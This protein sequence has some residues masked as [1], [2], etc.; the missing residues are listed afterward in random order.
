MKKNKRKS[1]NCTMLGVIMLRKQ[2]NGK[3]NN[4][5]S[6]TKSRQFRLSRGELE[7]KKMYAHT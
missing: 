6:I 3:E 7:E 1:I 4:L 5:K 2:V